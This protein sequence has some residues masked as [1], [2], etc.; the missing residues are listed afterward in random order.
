MLDFIYDRVG[1]PCLTSIA[2]VFYDTNIHEVDYPPY[3]A[4][5]G[6]V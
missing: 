3:D 2:M 5:A 1:W 4:V 6:N